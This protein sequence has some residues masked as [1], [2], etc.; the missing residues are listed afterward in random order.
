MK[1]KIFTLINICIIMVMFG[2]MIPKQVHA[3]T[4]YSLTFNT[5]GGN[6]DGPDKVTFTSP[7]SKFYFDNLPI[8]T[9][10]DVNGKPVVFIGWSAAASDTIYLI[11]DKPPVN[12]LF[13]AVG[14][15]VTVY[16]LWGY[17][18][19]NN[20]IADVNE[21][22]MVTFLDCDG[23][24]LQI[25][26]YSYGDY[27]RKISDPEIRADRSGYQEFLN[28]TPEFDDNGKK[29]YKNN[30]YT[31]EY[32]NKIPFDTENAMDNLQE[33]INTSPDGT[34]ITLDAGKVY[35]GDITLSKQVTITSAGRSYIRGKVIVPD[36]VSGSG[37]IT[38]EKCVI[39]GGIEIADGQAN[40]TLADNTIYYNDECPAVKVT[41][42]DNQAAKHYDKYKIGIAEVIYNGSVTEPARPNI[43]VNEGATDN[44][45]DRT[46]AALAIEWPFTT[47]PKSDGSK[48][49]DCLDVSVNYWRT[50]DISTDATFWDVNVT[51]TF[52]TVNGVE[53]R[54]TR[55]DGYVKFAKENSISPNSNLQF[56]RSVRL[57]P[58]ENFPWCISAE[59]AADRKT[60]KTDDRIW[61]ND[62]ALLLYNRSFSTNGT[63]APLFLN[64]ESD[65]MN[66]FRNDG[67]YE[68]SKL[69]KP[70]MFKYL[71][72]S[73]LKDSG[74]SPS[75]RY[76]ENI[77]LKDGSPLYIYSSKMYLPMDIPSKEMI[78]YAG[79]GGLSTN[80]PTVAYEF[81]LENVY[82]DPAA[83]TPPANTRGID[84]TKKYIEF[85]NNM[86][87]NT[88][89]FALQGPTLITKIYQENT[90]INSNTKGGLYSAKVSNA[91]ELITYESYFDSSILGNCNI[92]YGPTIAFF[93]PNSISSDFIV[94]PTSDDL[95][96]EPVISDLPTTPVDHPVVVINADAKYYDST[97][98]ASE[99]TGQLLDK[100]KVSLLNDNVEPTSENNTAMINAAKADVLTKNQFYEH[101]YLSL[102][103][104]DDGNNVVTTT[105]EKTVYIPY[106]DAYKK[107]MPLNIM[108]FDNYHRMPADSIS[109][110][111]LIP[112]NDITKL[113][114]GFT[115]TTTDDLGAY[116]IAYGEEAEELKYTLTFET[117]G[118]S[119]LSPIT[120]PGGTTIALA[121][122][123]ARDGYSFKG[124]YE[125]KA[126]SVPI[127]EVVLDADKTVYA[128]W[129]KN[130]VDPA[131]SDPGNPSKPGAGGNNGI[132]ATGD[133]N[134]IL[135]WGG[136]CLAS[137]LCLGIAAII[138]VK[139][140]RNK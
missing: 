120:K 31:A 14:S 5:N 45:E 2:L 40:V 116:I 54:G 26:D 13:I 88:Y 41:G 43:F 84:R 28:W 42:I 44:Y 83:A 73:V 19:N 129:E 117:N 62:A 1:N 96:V 93:K 133:T 136:I 33:T 91:P 108:H 80:F 107:D 37:N 69:A 52:S 32:S 55:W 138:I 132:T 110:Y 7:Q 86:Y 56:P 99:T 128:K 70:Y 134:N 11:N 95:S 127:T 104:V 64:V 74:S 82:Y 20:N 112:E 102:L 71:I 48:I 79:N 81:K 27:F 121:Q 125:D 58:P 30:T 77:N 65:E 131:P 90:E 94:R 76:P 115:F 75:F 39:D 18:E 47:Y 12:S 29:V 66:C 101:H 36:T 23:R 49:E 111:T 60:Q 106:P 124:W 63:A 35:D 98:G 85:P 92:F 34:V 17:D 118:G 137:L 3:E 25:N 103:N 59:T 8:P 53:G 87:G 139:K 72:G 119:E 100:G 38:V 4:S 46:A 109:S 130:T 114:D 97:K 113:A 78:A 123:P 68:N 126:L 67:T 6:A 50:G 135:L 140:K 89:D 122:I 9:H 57:M 61:Q 105:A 22:K 51:G 24:V 16:A 15:D 10:N 21:P